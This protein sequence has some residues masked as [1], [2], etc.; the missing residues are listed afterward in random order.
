MIVIVTV[1]IL[2]EEAEMTTLHHLVVAVPRPLNTRV[3][4]D[5]GGVRPSR[6]LVL[7][8]HQRCVVLALLHLLKTSTV[9]AT[10]RMTG[11]HRD[12]DDR[13][14]EVDRKLVMKP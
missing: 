13:E 8:R 4:Q 11:A 2:A 1:S 6:A 7:R 3:K 14:K 5:V 12:T 9:S 10:V